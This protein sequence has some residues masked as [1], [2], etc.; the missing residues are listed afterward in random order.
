M[1][2]FNNLE[3]FNNYNA[4][5]PT[6]RCEGQLWYNES[7]NFFYIGDLKFM[8]LD[9][10]DA[11]DPIT[12][13]KECAWDNN[14]VINF[15]NHKLKIKSLDDYNILKLALPANTLDFFDITIG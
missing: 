13:L 11:I 1:E 3:Y 10:P 14:I 6:Y 8:Q 2:H 5:I 9:A 12:Q 4:A 7:D 15:N